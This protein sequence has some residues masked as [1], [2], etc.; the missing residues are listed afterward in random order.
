MRRQAS[1]IFLF[2]LQ[3]CPK[4]RERKAE[5]VNSTDNLDNQLLQL[6][7]IRNEQWSAALPHFVGDVDDEIR[8]EVVVWLNGFEQID[9]ELMAVN[10]RSEF[11]LYADLE[12]PELCLDEVRLWVRVVGTQLIEFGGVKGRLLQG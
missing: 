12:Q 8:W 5:D 2:V 4:V 6:V 9:E 1:M 7:T 3:K 10:G 11:G